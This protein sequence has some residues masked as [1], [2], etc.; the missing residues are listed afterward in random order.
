MQFLCNKYSFLRW[1]LTKILNT[2]KHSSILEDGSPLLST[3]YIGHMTYLPPEVLAHTPYLP[4]PADIWSLGVCLV[5][6]IFQTVPFDGFMQEDVL[7]QQMKHSWKQCL[8]NK[9]QLARQPIKADV[10][11]VIDACLSLKPNER[12]NICDLIRTWD[13]VSSESLYPT[14]K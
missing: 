10:E 14:W 11:K 9:S 3:D 13:A 4:K 2:F 7:D 8:E 12:A 6:I 5:F 1:N